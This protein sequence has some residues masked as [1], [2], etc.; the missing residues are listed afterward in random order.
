MKSIELLQVASVKIYKSAY[1]DE[2][3]TSIYL[4]GD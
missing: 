4:A 2:A 3:S 1:H